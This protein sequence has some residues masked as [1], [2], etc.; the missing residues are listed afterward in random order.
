MSKRAEWATS[1]RP[2]SWAASSGST[3]SGGGAMSTIACVTPV[4]RW[5]PRDSG[6]PTDTSDDQESWSSPPPTSTAPTS[7][8]SQRSRGSPL[9]STST[10]RNSLVA[11][12]WESIPAEA[13]STTAMLR[14]APDS[15]QLRL[16]P[17]RL[18]GSHERR[19]RRPWR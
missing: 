16:Q 10:A 6:A 12:G 9:V 11:S 5:M 13:S 4:K 2:R 18:R 15:M 19:D 7:V 17:P 1:T 3:S 8:S 14:R